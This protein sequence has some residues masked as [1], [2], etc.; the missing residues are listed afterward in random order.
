MHI[1]VW[2]C[3]GEVYVCVC[4]CGGI[5]MYVCVF[6]WVCVCVHVSMFGNTFPTELYAEDVSAYLSC[7]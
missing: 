2:V 4:V 6:V 7:V 1:C 3:G 5:C